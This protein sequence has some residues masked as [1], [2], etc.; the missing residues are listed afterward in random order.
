MPCEQN[1]CEK[2]E[3]ADER[4]AFFFSFFLWFI[5][6]YLFI[7]AIFKITLPRIVTGT[8][9]SEERV[10]VTWGFAT[11]LIAPLE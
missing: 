7:F 3:K 9:L 11:W 5:L 6:F 1:V 4:K 8:S 10:T 2:E